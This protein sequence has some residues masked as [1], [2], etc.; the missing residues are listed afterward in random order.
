MASTEQFE[1]QF[2]GSMLE[3]GPEV[4]EVS[5]ESGATEEATFEDGD[6]MDETGYL[7]LLELK[8]GTPVEM[9]VFIGGY[10]YVYKLKRRYKV[11]PVTEELPEKT[12]LLTPGLD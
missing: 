2:P 11:E 6:T 5:S 9:E 12:G 10:W 8:T 7:G 1:S 3:D 4:P